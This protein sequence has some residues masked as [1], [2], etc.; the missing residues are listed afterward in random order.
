MRVFDLD[1]NRQGRDFAGHINVKGA[2][3]ANVQLTVKNYSL[4]VVRKGSSGAGLKNWRF[5]PESMLQLAHSLGAQM[6]RFGCVCVCVWC[7]CVL[8]VLRLVRLRFV[9][10]AFWLRF[11]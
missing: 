9:R 7:V 5:T 6:L 1:A 8:C 10:F 4:V 3:R 2:L 11:E